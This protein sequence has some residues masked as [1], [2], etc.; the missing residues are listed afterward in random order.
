MSLFI[1]S[2]ERYLRNIYEDYKLA[3]IDVGTIVKETPVK[4]AIGGVAC[5]VMSYMAYT[6]PSEEDFQ[7]V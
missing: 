3:I 4:S 1:L 2:P 6:N 5:S 7:Y